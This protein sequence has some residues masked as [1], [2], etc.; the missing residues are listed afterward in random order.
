[1]RDMFSSTT[2][3]L[4]INNWDIRKVN[5]TGMLNMFKGNT[6]MEEKNKPSIENYKEYH[7]YPARRL[8]VKGVLTDKGMPR[9]VLREMYGF[10]TDEP[11]SELEQMDIDAEFAKRYP[12]PTAVPEPTVTSAPTVT[13][14]PTTGPLGGRRSRRVRKTSRRKNKT[15]KRTRRTSRKRISRRK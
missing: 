14:A 11:G 7:V 4:P 1:M 9:G 8:A 13:P 12:A 10:M 2:Y 5:R 15:S 3:N 6:S